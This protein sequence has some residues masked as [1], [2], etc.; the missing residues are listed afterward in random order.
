MQDR[1]VK[2]LSRL[3]AI[4][5]RVTGGMIGRRL[6][7]NDMLLLTTEGTVT[8]S[9]HT[10]PL[11]Y[12]RDDDRLIVVASYGGRP[13]HPQWY[14]NLVA[15]PEATVRIGR[16]TATVTAS[17]MEA[18]DRARWW[19]VIVEAFADYATYQSRTEREIPLVWLDPD[20]LV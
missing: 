1:T 12:L 9:D 7:D 15:N 10:I 16:T 18:T 14:R 2:T 11:L 3:H 17:T 5:Y 8:G 4:A 19:P 20:D 13:D 6:A